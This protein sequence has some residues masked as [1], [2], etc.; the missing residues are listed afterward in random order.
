MSNL[1]AKDEVDILLRGVP[2]MFDGGSEF[3]DTGGRD[4]SELFQH[5]KEKDLWRGNLLSSR[6]KG[7]SRLYYRIVGVDHGMYTKVTVRRI[8]L[9]PFDILQL[10]VIGGLCMYIFDKLVPFFMG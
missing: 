2:G 9:H 7:E 5:V 4:L 1:L 10:I 6:R 8:W 3:C